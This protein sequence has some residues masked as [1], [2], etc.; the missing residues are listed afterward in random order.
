MEQSF[1]VAS[2]LAAHRVV[3]ANS[4]GNNTVIYPAATSV[5]P[6]GITK[7]TVLD[8]NEGIRVAGP[9]EIAKLFFNDTVAAGGLVGF[10]TQGRGVPVTSGA[11]ST[12]I[13]AGAG[14]IGILV[15]AAVATTGTIADVYILPN[16]IR[17]TA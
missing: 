7:D 4:S 17:V 2:T 12:A 10:D 1:K 15:G 5:L 13:S 11:T 14:V 9:G 16:I 3:A 8:T 6:L